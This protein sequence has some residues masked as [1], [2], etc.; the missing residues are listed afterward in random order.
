[1]RARGLFESNPML[2]VFEGLLRHATPGRIVGDFDARM[3]HVP[4]VTPAYDECAFVLKAYASELQVAALCDGQRALSQVL[5][6]SPYGMLDTLRILRALEVSGGVSFARQAL[7]AGPVDDSDTG[8][9]LVQAPAEPI[10]AEVV[11][12]PFAREVLET[13]LRTA[14][15]DHYGRL[16]VQRDASLATINVAYQRLVKRYHPDRVARLT[17]T[18]ARARGKELFIRLR[19]AH[20]ALTNPSVRAAYDAGLADREAPSQPEYADAE[21][22]ERGQAL[23]SRGRL[24]E[25]QRC[26]DYAAEQD[27][28]LGHYRVYR[29]FVRFQAL[30]P[31]HN[32]TR[33]RL[34]DE[35]RAALFDCQERDDC[36]VL[37]ARAYQG[38]GDSDVAARLYRRALTLNPENR[39]A[40]SDLRKLEGVRRAG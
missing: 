14:D 12:E 13:Y 23:L 15:A 7:V 37:V 27:P 11:S 8:R 30:D 21:I 25:A 22:F 33:V 1:M 20:Q 38:L 32:H 2:L 17:H 4:R 10:A 40:R 19:R 31:A 35:M 18:E 16:G 24:R 5:A 34:L 26:F 36:T 28:T 29:A 9:L 3:S 6:E 39:A